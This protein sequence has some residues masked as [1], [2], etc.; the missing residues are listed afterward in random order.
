MWYCSLVLVLLLITDNDLNLPQG[1]KA[2]TLSTL[3]DS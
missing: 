1:S 2:D 3:K